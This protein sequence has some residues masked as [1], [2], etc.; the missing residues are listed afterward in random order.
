T[1]STRVSDLPGSRLRSAVT[2]TPRA[3]PVEKSAAVSDTQIFTDAAPAAPGRRRRERRIGGGRRERRLTQTSEALRDSGARS[4]TP[5]P[6]G[7]AGR[8]A[9]ARVPGPAA[10]RRGPGHR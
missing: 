6:A 7:R 3:S 1:P 4:P 5:G 8:A 9:D 10:P 2:D